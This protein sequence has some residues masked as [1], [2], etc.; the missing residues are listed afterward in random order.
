MWVPL[1]IDVR[2]AETDLM[3]VVHHSAYVVWLEA[4]RIAW[5][6]AAGMPYT[7][8][9]ASG[10]HFAVTEIGIEYRTPA[11]FGDTVRLETRLVELR[12]R[13][14]GF[15]YQ[16]HCL[17]KDALLATGRSR[18]IC[19]DL[20]GQMT[21]IPQDVAERLTAGMARLMERTPPGMKQ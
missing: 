8:V 17:A 3:G 1:D 13:Q 7:E 20:A 2:F 14:V 5:M 12:S 21:R 6:N 15:E 10:H 9:A 4:G 16:L 11:Y 19:V 18:H